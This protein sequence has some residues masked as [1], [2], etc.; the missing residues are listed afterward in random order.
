MLHLCTFFNL[1]ESNSKA[2]FGTLP[3]NLT[4]SPGNKCNLIVVKRRP[5]NQSKAE[6]DPND[7]M[8]DAKFS[9]I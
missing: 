6:R 2:I 5:Y 9:I 3:L 1:S 8:V 7:G 4:K